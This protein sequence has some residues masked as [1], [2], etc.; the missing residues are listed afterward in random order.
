MLNLLYQVKE[1]A[2]L[3][4]YGNDLGL[5]KAKKKKTIIFLNSVEK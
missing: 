2:N 4:Y 3:G 5:S 1:K